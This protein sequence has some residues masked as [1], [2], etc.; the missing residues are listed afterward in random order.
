MGFF[1]GQYLTSLTKKNKGYNSLIFCRKFRVYKWEPLII[2][3]YCL[4]VSYFRG[5]QDLT[6]LHIS[7]ALLVTAVHVNLKVVDNTPE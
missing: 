7:K 4:Q 5:Q 6:F 3:G 1:Q 2:K